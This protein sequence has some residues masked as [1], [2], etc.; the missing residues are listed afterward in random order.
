PAHAYLKVC[1][2]ISDPVLNEIKPTSRGT[3]SQNNQQVA[4]QSLGT[5][6]QNR[7]MLRTEEVHTLHNKWQA[8]RMVTITV[9]Q[10]VRQIDKTRKITEKSHSTIELIKP[11]ERVKE[12][13]GSNVLK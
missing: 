9:T 3:E 6:V 2:A 5:T 13:A 10:S 12:E 4:L 1:S 7:S 11:G 8:N